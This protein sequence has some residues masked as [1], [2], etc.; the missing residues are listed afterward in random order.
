MTRVVLG[1]TGGQRRRWTLIAP[2]FIVALVAL[3][4]TAGAQAVHD[5]GFFELDRNAVATAAPGED[6]NLVCPTTTPVG[7]A[8]GC[9]GGTTSQTSAFKTDDARIYTGGS[10]KDDLDITGWLHTAGS[11]PDKDDLQHGYAAR[12]GTN[13]YFGADRFANNGDAQIGVWFFQSAV[14]P[15]ANGTFSGQ[16]IDGDVLVLSDF[17]KGGETSTIRVF[18]WNGPGGT[19]SGSGAINGTLDLLF[20]TTASPQDCVGPPALGTGDPACA[21]VNQVST[22]S[23][24]SFTPKTGAANSFAKGEFY[25]GGIDLSDPLLGLAGECFSSVILETR[26]S[27]STDAVLKDFVSAEFEHCGANISITPSGVNAVGSSHTFT[28][29]ITKTVSGATTGVSG[30]YP[31]VTLTPTAPLT[32]GDLTVSGNTCVD[33]GAGPNTGTDSD[34]KCTVTFTSSKAGI[35]TGH[36]EA[37]V[38]IGGTTFPVHT[39]SDATASSPD[40][41]KRFVDANVSISP[42]ATNAVGTA[43]TFTISTTASPAGTTASLTSITPIV[44]PAPGTLTSTCNAPSG[45]GDTRTCTVTINS[46]SAGTFTA[47]ATVVW[48]FTGTGTPS[49]ATVTRD[50]DPATAAIGSGPGGS[51]PAV[52]KY[53]DAAIS[54]SPSATNEV[55]T[56]HT[57]T[58]TLTAIPGNTGLSPSA[59]SL[60]STNV[61]PSPTTTG[62]TCPTLAGTGNT[63]TCTLVITN[64][65]AATFTANA[66]GSVT[67]DGIAMARDTDPATATTSGTGGS[68]PAIKK[69]VDAAISISPSATNEVGQT[70]TFTITLTAIPGNTGLSPSAFSLTSTNVSPAAGTTGGTCPTLAGSGNTRTCTL[71]ISNATA[72]TFVANAT[73]SV[74]IDGVAMARDTDP[75]T[76]TTSGTGGSGPATKKFVD[77]AISI[78]ASATNEVGHPHTFT[79]TLTAVPGNTGLSP[80]G[81][82]LTSTNV[83]PAPGTTG[84]TCPTLAGSG[85]TRTCTLVINNPTAGTFTANAT[86]TVTIDGVTMTRDTDPATSSTPSG[87]GGSGPATKTFVDANITIAPAEA[88]NVVGDLHTF[89]VTVR[90]DDG[91]PTS[92]GDGVNGMAVPAL[93]T[94][95]TVTLSND[96]TSQYNV[97]TDSCLNLLAGT[98]V[99]GQCFVVFSSPTAGTVTGNGSV[100]IKPADVGGVTGLTRDTDPATPA[101]SGPGGSG[102][103][104]KHF[105]AGSIRWTKVD[106]ANR[107]QGGATFELRQTHRYDIETSSFVDITDVVYT[108]VD[109]TNQAGYSGIDEDS[110]AGKFKVSGLPL[111]RYTVKE[112]EAPAGYE[113]DSDTET[114]ELTPGA[115]NTDKTIAT[116]FVNS[117]PILKITGFSYTNAADDPASQPDGI[118]KGTTTY[119][120]KLHNYGTAA[121]HLTNSSLVVSS[122]ATCTPTNTLDLTGTTIA[123]GADSSEF[124]LTCSYDHPA[125]AAITATLNVKYT[126][127]GTERT[128]SGSPATI[129]FTVA[130][131]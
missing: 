16:H 2:F 66:T 77:A 61:S 121:A 8:P 102:P 105:V 128:A 18:R 48:G 54:I 47:N 124:T 33:D 73:G 12:Y 31:T 26:S 112:T 51:G 64:S 99:N 82:S 76:A 94:Q 89:T 37:N 127:N 78:A 34:G 85:N 46:T 84:G 100:T 10:T 101:T 118:L 125:P 49:S 83:S 4:L 116:A 98:D 111:G 53:V 52:K 86:G 90:K 35:V 13:L 57:F 68:G 11:V 119:K 6:W 44:S 43:H 32:S 97:L 74:T 104:I 21:T 79:V 50:T 80:S 131:D 123:A 59:F 122:N 9:L 20:G 30:Q 42:S 36:A 87:P 5:D 120:L 58:V 19:I 129:T 70:H 75:A 67:I 56:A 130:A 81:F 15:Q 60:T 39:G 63:R 24:W 110:A 62:G 92:A 1:P 114:V 25:E 14:G 71:E 108:V 115:G 95:V 106:N 69:F 91:L 23:P 126:T 113:A 40:A 96:A 22:P 72:G 65:S 38:V 17:T 7:T 93:G 107:L 27:Q 3:M 117:R 109:N 103:A 55:G 28:V 29:A 45:T 41:T 88:T